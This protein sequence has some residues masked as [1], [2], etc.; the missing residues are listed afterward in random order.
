M[1]IIS[2]LGKWIHKDVLYGTG[3]NLCQPYFRVRMNKF[4]DIASQSKI[5][6]SK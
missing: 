3:N 5:I 2:V 6:N 1:L 4:K